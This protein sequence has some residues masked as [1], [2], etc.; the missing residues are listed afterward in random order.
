MAKKMGYQIPLY[1]G[2][3]GSSAG[4][5][6]ENCVDVSYDTSVETGS[7]TARGDGSSVPIDTGEAT[8]LKPSLTFKMIVDD[9]DTAL[10]TLVAS[11][12]SGVAVALR[13]DTFSCDCILSMQNAAP[14]KG[15]QTIDFTVEQVSA[16]DRDPIL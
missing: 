11:A 3:K 16:S 8:S 14:L 6:L 4:T 1:M 9:T 15:E 2:T 13:Y 10:A 12:R 7:T 5:L